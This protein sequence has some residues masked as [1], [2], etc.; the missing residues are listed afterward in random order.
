[1]NVL[2][3]LKTSTS[4]QWYKLYFPGGRVDLILQFLHYLQSVSIV[5]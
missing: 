5:F 2:R 3:M 4:Y 1:M